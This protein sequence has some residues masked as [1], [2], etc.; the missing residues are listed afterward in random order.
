MD[1]ESAKR[2][3]TV[4]LCEKVIVFYIKRLIWA[5]LNLSKTTKMKVLSVIQPAQHEGELFE[6]FFFF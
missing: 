4:Y 2:G 1:E 3:T 5:A 6:L